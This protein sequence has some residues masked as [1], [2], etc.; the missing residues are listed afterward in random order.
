MKNKCVLALL[1]VALFTAHTQD[2]AEAQQ[3]TPTVEPV[4]NGET[5]EEKRQNLPKGFL[6]DSISTLIERIESLEKAAKDEF[7]KTSERNDEVSRLRARPYRFVIS[8]EENLAYDKKS[9]SHL[10]SKIRC[11]Q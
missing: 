8:P 10:G 11:R 9:Q 6:G 2:K 3:G 1:L 7:T 4:T 5:P